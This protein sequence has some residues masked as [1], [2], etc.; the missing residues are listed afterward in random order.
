MK[1]I[2]K[3]TKQPAPQRLHVSLSDLLAAAGEVAFECSNSDKEAFDLAQVALIEILKNT[4]V[5]SDKDFEK[6]PSP[7]DLI[8]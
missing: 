7:A 4:S 5:T 8:H 1:T 6:L 2:D 3:P